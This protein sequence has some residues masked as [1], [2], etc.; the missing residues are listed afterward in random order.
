[1]P[2]E[3]VQTMS[4]KRAVHLRGERGQAFATLVRGIAPEQLLCVSLDISKYFHVVMIHNGL[5][6]IVTPTFEIDIYQSGFEQLCQ[7]IEQATA[8]THAQVV[9][10]GME[11]TSHY[12]ENLA[13]HLLERARPVTLI[14][15]F[16]VKQNRE[17]QLMR[18]EKTDQI[19][20]A[21]IGD[22][23]RRGEGTPYQPVSGL[24]LDLQ[25]L[26]RARL[27]KA[28]IA[29]ILKNQIIGHLD[30]I[31][32]GLVLL[33]PVAQERYTPLFRADIWHC[34]TLQDLIRACPNPHDLVTLS[35]QQLVQAFHAQQCRL[36]PVTAAKI[37]SQ[38]H[39]TLLPDPTLVTIRCELLHHDLALLEAVQTHLTSLEQRLTELVAQT[40][41]Q[42]WTTLK[43][44]SVVQVASLAAAIGDPAHYTAA[45]Q[46]FRRSGLVSGRN[47]SGKHQRKGKGHHVLKTGDVYL[48][49]ALMNAV[50][51]LILHQPVL[52]RYNQRLQMTKPAGVARVATARKAIGILWAILREQTSHTFITGKGADM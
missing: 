32:P 28:K 38:A 13:R 9:L 43:G 17:Q 26:D 30:R 12:F 35:P 42:I 15:S 37:I 20:V 51:T 31:F 34:R 45:A 44:L 52:T 11:P 8:Q 47:D 5:G 24:Y 40:P 14:N 7:A 36:G 18:C 1:M 19:D 33:D 50:A 21:A 48:R 6:E 29:G 4:P 23:L 16:A 25:Q 10:V 49:R 3:E 2:T 46:I 41:Y 39:H 22:L 27:G